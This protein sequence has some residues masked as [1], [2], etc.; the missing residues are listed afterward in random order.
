MRCTFSRR[1]PMVTRAAVIAVDMPRFASILALTVRAADEDVVRR[2]QSVRQGRRRHRANYR[3]CRRSVDQPPDAHSAR[4]ANNKLQL[5]VNLALANKSAGAIRR[6]PRRITSWRSTE[7]EPL[8][9]GQLPV[10]WGLCWQLCG[11]MYDEQGKAAH[12]CKL[13]PLQD[14]ALVR[15]GGRPQ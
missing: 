6:L 12:W 14:L 3:T 15:K 9:V 10:R 13:H 2:A 7:L 1:S 8:I 5:V 4:R 11:N